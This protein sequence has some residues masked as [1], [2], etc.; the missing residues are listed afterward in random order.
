[1]SSLTKTK[2][3]KN[4]L[5]VYEGELRN[6]KKNGYGI[7]YIN[8]LKEYEGFWKDDLYEGVGSYYQNGELLVSSYSKDKILIGL[9]KKG[10]FE[11]VG[12]EEKDI[13]DDSTIFYTHDG[14]GFY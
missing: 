13:M 3:F 11:S 5:L 2:L 4:N 9:W 7:S 12:S 8:G 10:I 1:M 14:V 6:N